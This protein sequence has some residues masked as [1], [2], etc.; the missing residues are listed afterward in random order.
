MPEYD[1]GVEIEA[2]GFIEC[3][4]TGTVVAPDPATAERMITSIIA[5]KVEPAARMDELVQIWPP[6][7]E[8]EE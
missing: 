2:A 6:T 4:V 5:R 7:D 1:F 8:G 3:W